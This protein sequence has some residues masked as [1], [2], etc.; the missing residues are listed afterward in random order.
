MPRQLRSRKVV[1]FAGVTLAAIAST[2]LISR[3]APC[4]VAVLFGVAFLLFQVLG[5][6]KGTARIFAWG[7]YGYYAFGLFGVVLF[8][9]GHSNEVAYLEAGLKVAETERQL[10]DLRDR[11]VN[12]ERWRSDPRLLA[13]CRAPR[14]P[15]VAGETQSNTRDPVIEA[16]TDAVGLGN[17]PKF[18]LKEIDA[19]EKQLV[20][21]RGARSKGPAAKTDSDLKLELLWS[22]SLVLVAI[23]FKL[24]KTTKACCGEKP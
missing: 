23:A 18:L 3:W 2:Y 11:R 7:E 24:G 5:L 16:C 19:L 22:Q 13:A 6:K 14:A 10:Q 21:Y 8:Y 1:C 4:A 12:A 17:D 15:R 9:A 20:S